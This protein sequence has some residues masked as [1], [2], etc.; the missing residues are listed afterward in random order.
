VGRAFM[1]EGALLALAGGESYLYE[2]H[3]YF[4]RNKDAR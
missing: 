4:E 3:A 1:G 2:R